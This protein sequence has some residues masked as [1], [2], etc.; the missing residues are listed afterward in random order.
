MRIAVDSDVG[1]DGAEFNSLCCKY[2]QS[3]EKFFYPIR[4]SLINVLYLARTCEM[5]L[6]NQMLNLS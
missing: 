4:V 1:Y 5:R 6:L 2:F 3:L